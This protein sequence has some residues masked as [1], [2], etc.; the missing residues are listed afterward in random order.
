MQHAYIRDA[1]RT[2]FGR[3]GGAIAVGDRYALCTLCIGVD[4]GIAVIIKRCGDQ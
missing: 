1:V 2:P 4:Q 3:Y